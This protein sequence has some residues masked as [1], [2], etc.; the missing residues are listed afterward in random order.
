[1]NALLGPLEL[2]P[3][4]HGGHVV[5]RHEGRVVFVRGGLPGEQVLVEL[6]DTRH[7]R[8]WKGRVHQVLEASPGRVEQELPPAAYAG[9][10][11]AFASLEAQRRLKAQVIAEQLARL[12]GVDAEVEVEAV[13]G[14][15]DG[16]GWRTRMRYLHAGGRVGLR[17]FHSS[18]LVEAPPGTGFLLADPR[19]PAPADLARYAARAGR[20]ITVTV[21]DSGVSVMSDGRVLSGEP[22]VTQQ[23]RG[24]DFRVRADGFW[25]VHPGAADALTGAVLDALGVR[26]GERALDLY[27]GVGL[28]AGALARAG[29]RVTG[30]EMDGPAVR[31]ARSNVPQ[32]RF[33]ASRLEQGLT[34]LGERSDVVVLDPPRSGAGRRVIE[35]IAG[36]SARCIGYVA[37]DPAALGRDVARLRALG[38]ELA[39]VRAFDIFPMTHHVETVALLSREKSLDRPGSVRPARTGGR[40][41]VS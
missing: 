6:T 16:W 19:G 8:F 14:D 37:C 34:R 35:A 30:M 25:Q 21:A 23:V 4:A 17:G 1:M 9:S 36:L 26:E 11:F 10:D 28:F 31:L 18:E 27:C 39:S 2:G 41:A 22:V 15:R 13:P 24:M 33:I 12:G 38:Y 29:A 5:A 32:A 20:E 7:D 40:G 3:I